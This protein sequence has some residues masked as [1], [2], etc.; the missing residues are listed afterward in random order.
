VQDA[1]PLVADH[2]ETVRQLQ[3]DTDA[4]KKELD[5]VRAA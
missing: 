5:S 4:L 2:E 1:T 3:A